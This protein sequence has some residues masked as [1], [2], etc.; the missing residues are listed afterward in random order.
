MISTNSRIDALEAPVIKRHSTMTFG[1]SL[2]L[3][4]SLSGCGGCDIAGI[5]GGGGGG[6]GE[7]EGEGEGEEG[8]GETGP[9]DVAR[10]RIDPAT[11]TLTGDGLT[12]PSQTFSVT[13]VYGDDREED[14]SATAAYALLREDLGT[15]SAGTFTSSGIAGTTRL[16]AL[17][18]GASTTAEITVKM[19]S[20]I[21]GDGSIP[22]DV[23]DRF[24][25][26]P[27]DQG[28]A[29]V[30]VYPADGVLLPKNL[31]VIEI[32]WRPGSAANS[33]YEVH[34]SSTLLDVRLFTRCTALNGG[35]FYTPDAALWRLLS[36]TH[37]GLD[38]ITVSVR[39]T[40]DAGSG[41]GTS[42]NIAMSFSA[43]GVDGALYYWTTSSTSIQRVDFGPGAV[44]E[45]FFPFG[46]GGCYGCHSISPDGRRMSLSRDGQNAG[47]LGLIDV[48]AGVESL[49]FTNAQREQF[50]SWDPTSSFF[51]GIFGDT[52]DLAVRHQVRIHSGDTG[53]VVDAI[54]LD[55]EP[56]HPDWSPTGD[57]LTVTRVTHHSTSQRP[58][59]GGI[60]TIPREGNAWGAPVEL[61]PA[62]DGKNRYTPATSLDGEFVVYVEST[63]NG[64]TY[65]G[66]CDGDADPS[67]RL[68]AVSTSGGA[69]VV[70]DNANRPGVEDGN[71]PNLSMTFP[72][73][74]PFEE[75]RFADGTGRVQWLTFSS[76]REYGLRDQGDD[77][78]G[79]QWLW[80]VA[81]NPDRV[82]AGEDGSF[83]AFALPFQDLSTSNHIGQWTQEFIEVGCTDEGL[84]CTPGETECCGDLA[85]V[86]QGEGAPIC[87]R[88]AG[89]GEG[90]GE[91]EICVAAGGACD[92]G[93]ANCCDVAAQC[94][95]GGSG[96]ICI[97]IGG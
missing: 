82:A 90:E 12:N 81:V 77:N 7:G 41:V 58:G 74:A 80:M 86:A 35:C 65:G 96:P 25:N 48:A 24:D 13:A 64:G 53:A 91:G 85:C 62:V 66:E 88:I 54:N 22:A 68:F 8:E 87:A 20:I 14:V 94:L 84:I 89:E 79:K 1:L 72:K 31:G 21:I 16:V 40:D 60:V 4:A 27:E 43:E 50:Q 30:L 9:D 18:G 95:D 10:L 70:L 45:Q 19:N 92:P 47:Q 39:G 73:W 97:N 32:H 63:C 57:R 83:A 46:G 15:V 52:S 71:N 36:E 44:P 55:F 6:G 42:G 11:I 49:G 34:F 61:V 76:R 78:N 37:A 75:P 56:D 59:R 2:L 69:P 38:P 28:R 51:A 67:A 26:A 23:A 29:P 17:F 3:L 33:L 93:N 5:G